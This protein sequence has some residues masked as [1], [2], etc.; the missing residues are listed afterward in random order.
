MREGSR[1]GLI[2]VVVVAVVALAAV[3]F[4]GGSG[5]RTPARI[6]PSAASG[7]ID[8][9]SASATTVAL[10]PV[11]PGTASRAAPARLAVP[12]TLPPPTTTTLAPP[13]IVSGRGT[14]LVRPGFT[15]VRTAD[16]N[17]CSAVDDGPQWSTRCG[18]AHAA[19]GDLM[20]AVE[21]RPIAGGSAWHIYA[22]RHLQGYQWLV[23]LAV[24]DETGQQQ[25]TAVHGAAVDVTGDGSQDLVFGFHYPE[26]GASLV[27]DVVS[28]AGRVNLHR[29]Y[30]EGAVQLN[31][32]QLDGYG[33]GPGG[34]GYGHEVLRYLSGAWRIVGSTP[35]PPVIPPS[36]V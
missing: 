7:R 8:D 9:R 18:L 21:R 29:W 23:A 13:P 1:F 11:P 26:P 20:W 22:L 35:T 24:A 31:P 6:R 12:T 19:G 25:W 34:V 36:S 15:Y 27:V 33:A 32:G 2:G 10:A 16:P 28:G 17:N 30:L 4:N 14:F 3:L 5:G